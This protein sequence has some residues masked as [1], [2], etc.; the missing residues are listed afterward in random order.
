MPT[1]LLQD[2]VN[3]LTFS[4]ADFLRLDFAHDP[5]AWLVVGATACFAIGAW[6]VL[7]AIEKAWKRIA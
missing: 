1:N 4:P 7:P 2:I 5:F 3:F 6:Q